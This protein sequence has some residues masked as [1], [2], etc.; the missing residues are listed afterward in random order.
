MGLKEDGATKA[1]YAAP[2]SRRQASFSAAAS[3]EAVRTL[4]AA[5][6]SYFIST[7]SKFLGIIL[8]LNITI[9]S[10]CTAKPNLGVSPLT[11]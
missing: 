6:M 3:F 4:Y 10:C 11:L 9:P 1:P 2:T 5:T 8:P 7:A